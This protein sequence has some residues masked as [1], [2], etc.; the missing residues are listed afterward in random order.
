MR[1]L[2]DC[3]RATLE[4]MEATA[5]SPSMRIYN[6]NAISFILE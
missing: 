1:Y 5:E 4:I 6:V 3:L 2:E